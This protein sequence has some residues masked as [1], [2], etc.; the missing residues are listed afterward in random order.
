MG[1][2]WPLGE[3]WV[4]TRSCQWC[5]SSA[6]PLDSSCHGGWLSS[7]VHL[8]CRG[9]VLLLWQGPCVPGQMCGRLPVSPAP[10]L[11]LLSEEC[12]AQSGQASLWQ[13]CLLSSPQ[14]VYGQ[15]G[16]ALLM[17]LGTFITIASSRRAPALI[18][19]PSPSLNRRFFNR[20]GSSH[21]QH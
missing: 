13:P 9:L 14:K 10:S 1:R 18:S 11:W 6:Q 15:L 5:Q 19:C 16:A 7:G 20:V 2:G 4:L 3:L 12:V 21:A 8:Q 17:Q